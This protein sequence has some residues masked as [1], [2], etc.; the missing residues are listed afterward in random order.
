MLKRKLDLGANFN[1]SLLS[2]VKMNMD[3]LTLSERPSSSKSETNSFVDSG[4]MSEETEEKNDVVP[5]EIENCYSAFNDDFEFLTMATVESDPQGIMRSSLYENLKEFVSKAPISKR[6]QEIEIESAIE[7]SDG[8]FT[9][10]TGSEK[11]M[12]MSSSLDSKQ[13]LLCKKD[14]PTKL[15]SKRRRRKKSCAKLDSN[16]V[17]QRL[18]ETRE[19]KV[20]D[21]TQKKKGFQKR[22]ID[23]SPV[24]SGVSSSKPSINKLSF[25]ANSTNSAHIDP[26]SCYCPSSQNQIQCSKAIEKISTVKIVRYLLSSTHCKKILLN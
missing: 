14:L 10:E 11:W 8:S 15:R 19:K 21:I 25:E 9:D 1:V 4:C 17:P 7:L 12:E 16:L 6:I 5:Q 3:D 22:A 20:E 24:S 26:Q 2:S 18:L 23:L 13:S